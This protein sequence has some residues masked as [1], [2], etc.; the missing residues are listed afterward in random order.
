MEPSGSFREQVVKKFFA[1]F[2]DAEVVTVESG[3]LYRW[4]LRR[5]PYSVSMFVTL[6]SPERED[7]AHVMISDSA[8][9]QVEPVVAV[10]VY[11][12]NEADALIDRIIKQWKS[13]Q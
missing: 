5:G 9:Q 7:I 3:N 12:L 4:T 2:G 11:T 6:D 8:H 1:A 10:T 13:V